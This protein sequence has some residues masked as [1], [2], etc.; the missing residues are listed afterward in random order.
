MLN[1][2]C[3][4]IRNYFTYRN[5]I[6]IGDYKIEGGI[7][8]PPVDFKDNEYIRIIGSR[9]NDGVHKITEELEDEGEFHGSI[10]RMSPPKDF[11]QLVADIEAWQEK[12]GT[13]DSAAMSPFNS[14]S[15]GGYSYSKSSGNSNEGAYD[16][17]W[18]A[19]FASRLKM[20]RRI[21]VI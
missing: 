16:N 10:W 18:K 7:I 6:L 12:N 4:E 8:T 2:V 17:S 13:V 20:Y 5:D 21:R 11:L 9:K 1:E 3:A 14:E 15:F 19:P